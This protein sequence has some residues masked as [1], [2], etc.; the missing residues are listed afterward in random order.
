M[1]RAARR[2]SPG[3]LVVKAVSGDIHVRVAR[4][5][6]VDVNGNTVSGDMGTEIDLSG[7]GDPRDDEELVYIKI[8]TVSGDI[9]IGKAT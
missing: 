7:S 9:R 1:R 6:G 5:L 3:Q 8:S 2:L 4:G